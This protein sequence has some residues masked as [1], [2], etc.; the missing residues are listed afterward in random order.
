[1]STSITINIAFPLPAPDIEALIEGRMIV[2]M[3]R[4]FVHPGKQFALYP[5][6]TSIKPL[7]TEQY[8]CPN[9]LPTVQ[10][11]LA[12]LDTQTVL[13]QAWAKCE[14][15]Q[16]LDPAESFKTLSQLT[17][18]TEAAFQ[19]NCS[20][21][22]H[23]FLIYLRV[24]QLTEPVAAIPVQSPAGFIRL[25]QVIRTN[26][27]IPVLSNHIFVEQRQQLE[28]R[29]PPKHPELQELYSAI[30]QL[31]DS[32]P[33]AKALDEN[34]R[35]FLGWSRQQ[36]IQ[37]YPP[38]LTWINTITDLGNR[39]KEQDQGKSNY[40]AG[41]D[42]ENVVR[43]SLEFLGFTI[44]E[45]HK[46]GAGGLDLFCSQPYPLVG[47]CKAGKK[48]PND[49][50]VQLLNLGTLRLQD[51][52]LLQQTAKLIIGPGVPT[53][54]LA[55]AAKVHNMAIINPET[56]EKLVK[57]QALYPNSVDLFQLKKHLIPGQADDQVAEYITQ[58]QEKIKLRSHLVQLV[59]DYLQNAKLED[60]GVDALHG[61]YFGSQPSQPLTPE[62]M[63]E[64]LIELS[65]P[66]AG[67]LGRIKDSD[68]RRDRFY[69]LRELS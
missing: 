34:I 33:A 51:K 47:E 38:H 29:Q 17:V 14:L 68:W 3:S 26:E 40:Q 32:N 4:K 63:H 22:G 28:N 50:A 8:Y 36:T 61:I 1:M 65:S 24:Y 23:I 55:D 45:S 53:P 20:Q 49:T 42:F 43:D 12:K 58:V 69:F 46:G 11:T 6:E 60:A 64:I 62:E 59:K 19:A 21:Q 39:S 35:R 44:D 37:Q 57:L 7:S 31:S 9:F 16:G 67:Y 30:T 10:K 25:P 27:A 15:C 56:L 41:T 13:L 48:I 18:W 66:L 54:Q 52:E 5:C 2:A